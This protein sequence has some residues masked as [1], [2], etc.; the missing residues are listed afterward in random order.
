MAAFHAMMFHMED[1]HRHQW[2]LAS[3][4]LHGYLVVAML[5]IR[6]KQ[7][8]AQNAVIVDCRLLQLIF[9]HI[10]LAQYMLWP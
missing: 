3:L 9:Y 7:F 5:Q 2:L 10:V 8:V 1:F 4:H 6:G